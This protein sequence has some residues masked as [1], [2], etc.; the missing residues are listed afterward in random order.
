MSPEGL[1]VRS[2]AFR[3][4]LATGLASTTGCQKLLV[5]PDA[6]LLGGHYNASVFTLA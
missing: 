4:R 5:Q 1:A 3:P 6:K 2:V